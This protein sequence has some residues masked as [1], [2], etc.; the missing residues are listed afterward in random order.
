M[1][2]K[3]NNQRKP[4][5]LPLEVKPLTYPYVVISGTGSYITACPTREAAT[6]VIEDKLKVSTPLTPYFI[7]EPTEV[8][9]VSGTPVV[10]R[11]I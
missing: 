4:L 1:K 8:L 9:Y 11:N 10:R 5:E 6:K 7:L 2:R 3:T